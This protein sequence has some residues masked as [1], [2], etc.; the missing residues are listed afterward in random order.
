MSYKE[1]VAAVSELKASKAVFVLSLARDWDGKNKLE[2]K[3]KDKI[4]NSPNPN[5]AFSKLAVNFFEERYNSDKKRYEV[6][7]PDILAKMNKLI[8][9]NI[10]SFLKDFSEQKNFGETKQG[11]WYHRHALE[12]GFD[13]YKE[14]F[15][16]IAKYMLVNNITSRSDRDNVHVKNTSA[17]LQLIFEKN[18]DENHIV[19]RKRRRRRR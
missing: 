14:T 5:N 1:A 12:N 19:G 9:E 10:A 3:L 17:L 7:N 13:R 2:G 4:T 15:Y 6:N 18:F 11:K 8:K 16:S